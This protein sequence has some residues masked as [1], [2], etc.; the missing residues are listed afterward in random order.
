MRS[1]G[2]NRWAPS[3]KP[4]TCPTTM[5]PITSGSFGSVSSPLTTWRS[6]RQTAQTETRIKTWRADG[7][8]AGTSPRR[9]GSFAARSRIALMASRLG[10]DPALQRCA[11]GDGRGGQRLRDRTVLLGVLGEL[12][13]RRLIDPGHVA[14]GR[15]ID[16]GYPPAI[17]ALVEM[18]AGR[19]PNFLRLVA[20]LRQPIGECHRKASSMRRADQLFRIRPGAV[21]HTALEGIRPLEGAAPQPHRS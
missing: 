9:R 15:E 14:F 7:T 3:P 1:P 12:L 17:V 10:G 16:P 19:G 18:D 13:E 20:G 11:Q 8:G 21:L 6:V 2:A 4:S 5:C